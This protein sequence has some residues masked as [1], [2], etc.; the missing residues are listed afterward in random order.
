MASSIPSVTQQGNARSNAQPPA[1]DMSALLQG[2]SP[3]Q[4]AV[5]GH[6][7]QTGQLQLPPQPPQTLVPTPNQDARPSTEGVNGVRPTSNG[8]TNGV[9]A[10]KEEGEWDEDDMDISGQ[11]DFLHP[12]PTGP[13]KR[14]P[15]ATDRRR[16]PSDGKN[17]VRKP[18]VTHPS[19]LVSARVSAHRQ[20]R[21][22]A[23]KSFIV[24]VHEAGFS[25]DDLASEVN[26]AR[27]LRLLYHE[28]GLGVAPV[29]KQLEDV[30]TS[31][32]PF[33]Q[34][35]PVPQAKASNLIPA[36]S[37]Q[38]ANTALP[39]ADRNTLTKPAAATPATSALP[40]TA[41]G[42]KKT[43]PVKP[44]EAGDRSAYLAR[45]QALKS[46]AAAP[47]SKA[48]ATDVAPSQSAA[49]LI[50]EPPAS[51]TATKQTRPMPAAMPTA[52]RELPAQP[53]IGTNPPMMPAEARPKTQINTELVK[54]R[55]AALK[56]ART[57]KD[58]GD[59]TPGSAQPGSQLGGASGTAMY[60]AVAQAVHAAAPDLSSQHVHDAVA[61]I[62][63]QAVQPTPLPTAG[64]QDSSS[65]VAMQHMHGP[66]SSQQQPPAPL[67]STSVYS[68]SGPSFGGLPG[69]PGLF[70]SG[71]PFG[72]QLPG[73][74]FPSAPPTQTTFATQPIASSVPKAALGHTSSN[75]LSTY[76]S[77]SSSHLNS[78]FSPS[79]PGNSVALSAIAAGV[80]RG[81]TA[82]ST[83]P[84]KRTFGKSVVDHVVI[85]NSDEEGEVDDEDDMD[86]EDADTSATTNVPATTPGDRHAQ[87][88]LPPSAV[89]LPSL[90]SF[91][92]DM[93]S[94]SS[95]P[96]GTPYH[97]KLLEIQEMNKRIENMRAQKAKA[98]G[99]STPVQN[100]TLTAV[101]TV[102][103]ATPGTGAVGEAA[104]PP[105]GPS[106]ES[107]A[108]MLVQADEASDKLSDSSTA[109]EMDLS[110][111][112][113]GEIEEDVPSEQVAIAV[114]DEAADE[115]Y[116]I[117]LL[118]Q[119]DDLQDGSATD[120]ANKTNA[121]AQLGQSAA[122]QSEDES[123][124]DSSDAKIEEI[125]APVPVSTVAEH[126]RDVDSSDASSIDDSDAEM[127]GSAQPAVL[128]STLPS[129]TVN[130]QP[131]PTSPL[132]SAEQAMSLSSDEESE[133]D[134][135]PEDMR[136]MLESAGD[137]PSTSGS[138]QQSA[139]SQDLHPP[140]TGVVPFQIED[141]T[142]TAQQP[143]RTKEE[144]LAMGREK[145][146][147]EERLSE[148]ARKARIAVKL[149]ELGNAGM[150]RA[151]RNAAA[152][153]SMAPAPL[154]ADSPGLQLSTV[155]TDSEN[156]AQVYDLDV[157]PELQPA[158][159]KK[160]DEIEEPDEQPK[161]RF[162]PYQTPLARFKNF[163][164]HPEFN[165]Y[166]PG[167]HKSLTYNN[168]IK[169]QVAL[170][171]TELDDS[172]LLRVYGT[173]NIPAGTPESKQRWKQ[174]LGAVVKALRGT[175]SGKDVN[176]IADVI[177]KFRRDFLNA[178]DR[179][180]DLGL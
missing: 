53:A 4:L 82:I 156:F 128:P 7:F 145:L 97:R 104:A 95:T 76:D 138:L 1:V 155:A 124:D 120:V 54:Q 147:E 18:S 20:A 38:S 40:R 119:D 102:P 150:S 166:V 9:A 21:R 160:V 149:A 29:R 106:I 69:L 49:S 80:K 13:R 170:C 85:D 167:G 67:A 60:N 139:P 146:L 152:G 101:D 23:A 43:A 136:E 19:P 73:L 117:E 143:V 178:P 72:T 5:I 39:T 159:E 158:R 176:A 177:V 93:T 83:Y 56:E 15:S 44:A 164:Y 27:L 78:V 122:Q 92:A 22:D 115:H 55:L 65:S 175:D 112:E 142:A 140:P 123:S 116:E 94:G 110:S 96:G 45:L 77:D 100:G 114:E 179:V 50:S 165:S 107:A 163:R 42:I 130:T 59:M 64:V 68:P 148:E 10:D 125:P 121:E 51:V 24:A 28:L 153:S 180:L 168:K 33:D 89:A 37:S 52:A 48:S 171:S 11:R 16:R 17:R 30:S 137:D 26:D 62:A 81:S 154:Q 113:D 70:M 46:K 41:P 98:R 109:D 144:V 133:D 88:A 84:S 141:V 74:P 35:A 161:S 57:R 8:H 162:T 108:N 31:T 86:I 6:L 174:G 66:P 134:Y 105:A 75:A 169:D 126:P 79:D 157:A 3:E 71:S 32:R 90:G 2:I 173:N 111:E 34:V 129:S 172:D 151:E 61:A 12:P 25:F 131:A 36:T 47:A 132:D 87:N 99:S 63:S 118:G 127:Y 58:G 14:S 91:T 103:T 135:E